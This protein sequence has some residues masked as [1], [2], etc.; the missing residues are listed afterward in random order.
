MSSYNQRFKSLFRRYL[1][2]GILVDCLTLL[3]GTAHSKEGAV[4]GEQKQTMRRE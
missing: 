2:F 3:Y 4:Y 1:T